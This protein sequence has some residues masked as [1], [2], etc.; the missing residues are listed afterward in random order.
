[1]SALL[2]KADIGSYPSQGKGHI[3]AGPT[4]LFNSVP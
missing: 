1:M 3:S 2:S 4:S